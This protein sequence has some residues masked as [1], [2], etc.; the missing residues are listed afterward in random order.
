MMDRENKKQ[1]NLKRK[2]ECDHHDE[3]QN[4]V[5]KKLRLDS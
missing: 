5:I 3:S 4:S 1:Q 2:C